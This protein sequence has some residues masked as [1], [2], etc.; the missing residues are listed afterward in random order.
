MLS[1]PHILCLCRVP[2]SS[3]V[4]SVIP[5]G[6]PAC[7]HSGAAWLSNMASFLPRWPLQ[8]SPLLALFQSLSIAYTGLE[9]DPPTSA[10]STVL[11]PQTYATTPA[12][13]LDFSV[14]MDTS[15]VNL[16]HEQPGREGCLLLYPWLYSEALPVCAS[17][18]NG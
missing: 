5:R 17:L 1:P 13:L 8:N 2:P 7:W 15:C 10:S 3:L 4:Y 18:R 12:C 6:R 11:A 16:F 14:S 9:S